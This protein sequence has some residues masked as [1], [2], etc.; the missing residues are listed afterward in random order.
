MSSL[1]L[2]DAEPAVC[3][4]HR[5]GVSRRCRCIFAAWRNLRS[6]VH[7]YLGVRFFCRWASDLSIASLSLSSLAFGSYKVTFCG[8]FAM[9]SGS[10]VRVRLPC[11]IAGRIGGKSDEWGFVWSSGQGDHST[12]DILTPACQANRP[13]AWLSRIARSA[14][15]TISM[16]F[17]PLELLER[18]AHGAEDGR[19][20]GIGI[21]ADLTNKT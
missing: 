9:P 14:M 18:C 8:R 16:A 2:I 11:C 10:G 6:L 21:F 7:H 12:S 13:C 19:V 1:R 5:L 4:T 17:L 3:R 20:K 15:K